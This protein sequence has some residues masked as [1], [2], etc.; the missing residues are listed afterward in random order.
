MLFFLNRLMYE[1]GAEE[2]EIRR[3]FLLWAGRG[4]LILVMALLER[5]AILAALEAIYHLDALAIYNVRYRKFFGDIFTAENE[6]QMVL[7]RFFMKYYINALVYLPITVLVFSFFWIGICAVYFGIKKKDGLLPVC[8]AVL[9]LMPIAMSLVEGMATRYRSAQYVPVV[10]AFAVFLL[11]AVLYMR[12]SSQRLKGFWALFLS[13]VLFNQVSET[14]RWLYVDYMKYQDMARVMDTVAHDLKRGFDT[15]KP[16]VLRGA[17]KVP[18]EIAKEAY[19][20]FDSWQFRMICRLTDSFDVHIKEKYYA[21]GAPAYVFA[22]MPIVSAMQWGL[23][24]FDG[25][26]RQL[27]NFWHM[28]GIG[29]LDCVTDL[30]VIE[31][32]ERIRTESGM[33]GY[34]RDG[35]IKECEDYIIVN[36]EN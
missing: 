4:L 14:N 12:K 33:P 30:N 16:I 29:G 13:I 10:S 24:A 36:L 18:Y 5:A 27:I 19:V 17:Y 26:S 20:G 31:E 35:Y 23:T 15:S 28:R 21:E 3:D 1:R 8:S 11:F 6:L 9:P 22:E 34:P 25:T 7:K 32:A 2:G